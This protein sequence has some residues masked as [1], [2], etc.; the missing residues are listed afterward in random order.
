MHDYSATFA[1][2]NKVEYTQKCIESLQQSNFDMSRLVVVDNN[3]KDSTWDYLQTIPSIH[4]IRNKDNMGCGVAWNQGILHLQTEWTVIMNNDI[5][6]SHD[7]INQ[8]IDHAIANNLKV[9][10]P[11]YIEGDSNY[12]FHGVSTDLQAKMNGYI[13][14]GYAN[15]IC[16]LVHK[17]V[18]PEVGYFRATPKLLGFE[19]T[20][21]FFDLMKAGIDHACVS[22]SWIH[23]FGSV[24]V[25][26]M[27]EEHRAKGGKGNMG[28]RD[29][30][31]FLDQSWFMRKLRK[32][33][34]K[35][36]IASQRTFELETFGSTVHAVRKDD[37]MHWY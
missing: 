34:R 13:R 24:T 37:E 4:T 19:D 35:A 25:K 21:F 6:V 17:S 14:P 27:N 30:H 11:A 7:W 15:A 33:N 20:I 1:C 29:N 36:L 28:R 10:S 8:L 9:A 5:L 2:F 23:H 22:G 18:W 26:A 31:R 16:L 12:D 3:S 32:R